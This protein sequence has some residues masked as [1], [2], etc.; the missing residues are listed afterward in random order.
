MGTVRSGR[1][2][3][4]MDKGEVSTGTQHGF[5]ASSALGL[6]QQEG[7]EGMFDVCCHRL[8]EDS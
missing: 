7:W 6:T 4:S 8:M 1:G 2:C 5:P 3:L